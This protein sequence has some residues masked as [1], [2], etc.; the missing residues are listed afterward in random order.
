M[1]MFQDTINPIFILLLIIFS[2]CATGCQTVHVP[3]VNNAAEAEACRAKVA[4]LQADLVVLN[5]WANPAEAGTG[6]AN[7]Y[8]IFLPAGRRI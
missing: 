1:R 7:R 5:N 6:G 4:S 3:S 8:S 2:F